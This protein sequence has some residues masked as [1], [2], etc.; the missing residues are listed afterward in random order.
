MRVPP[1]FSQQL[2][3]WQCLKPVIKSYA[4]LK[5]HI[6]DF[7]PRCY[8]WCACFLVGAISCRLYFRRHPPT[9]EE[10][11]NAGIILDLKHEKEVSPLISFFPEIAAASC[12]LDGVDRVGSVVMEMTYPHGHGKGK[13]SHA[14]TGGQCARSL[15]HRGG[16]WREGGR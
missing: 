1:S 16:G 9:S 14:I 4:A 12:K 8:G 2:R 11:Q 6:A 10:L 13:I 15:L 7:Y 3:G 5:E